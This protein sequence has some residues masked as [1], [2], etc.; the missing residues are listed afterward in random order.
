MVELYN[1]HMLSSS[2]LIK[3]NRYWSAMTGENWKKGKTL[4]RRKS[5][6]NM[7]LSPYH[8]DYVGWVIWLDGYHTIGLSYHPLLCFESML[9][10][11]FSVADMF[12][13]SHLIQS[14]SFA[15]S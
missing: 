10:I 2:S 3:I 8:H 5:L 6:L 13:R 7:T 14:S 11:H 12:K 9:P 1:K 15:I 4:Y